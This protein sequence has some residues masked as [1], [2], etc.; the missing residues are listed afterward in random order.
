M[1]LREIVWE[2]INWLHLAQ[3]KDWW[4]VPVNVARNLQVSQEVENFLTSTV[5]YLFLNDPD[6]WTQFKE[7]QFV[8]LVNNN[9]FKFVFLTFQTFFLLTPAEAM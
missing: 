5:Q 4:W 2:S 3:E 6:P 8:K 9:I 1:A 7:Q